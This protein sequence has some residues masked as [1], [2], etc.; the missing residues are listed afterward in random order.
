MCLPA[1]FQPFDFVGDRVVMCGDLVLMLCG[2]LVLML[3]D[4]KQVFFAPPGHP[5]SLLI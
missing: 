2:D 3:R 4:R 1:C 5:L